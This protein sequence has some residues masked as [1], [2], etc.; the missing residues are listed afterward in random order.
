MSQG[1]VGGRDDEYWLSEV[2]AFLGLSLVSGVGF[3]TLQKIAKKGM[4]F[5]HLLKSSSPTSL[6]SL[7]RTDIPEDLESW[8]RYQ[9]ELWSRGQDEARR[10][11]KASIRVVFA[12]QESFPAN[13]KN[14]P[15]PPYWLFITGDIDNLRRKAVAIVGTRKPTSDGEFL[16]KL[17]VATLA[18]R[19]LCTVSGLASGID[20]IIH[21]ES[22]RYKIPTV[23]VLGTGIENDYPH[24]SGG[25]K[26]SIL[27]AGGTVITEYLPDQS[28][29]ADN[30]IRRNRIQAALADSLVP[31]EYGIK[32]GTAHTVGF[33]STYG[34]RIANIYLPGSYDVRPELQFSERNRGA[35]SFEVP[36]D[37]ISFVEFILGEGELKPEVLQHEIEI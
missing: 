8:R 21:Q 23:A 7:V 13:L 3:W 28:Y 15:D 27:A 31:V 10:L 29:S 26:A 22:L 11:A 32:S 19:E 17:V 24:G 20:Q 12:G 14:I 33:A 25:L 16:S 37:L 6:K 9:K 1:Q 36:G 2:V 5:Q 34:K 35:L 30:F 4:S 18:K